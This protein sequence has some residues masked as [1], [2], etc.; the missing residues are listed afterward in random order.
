MLRKDAWVDWEKSVVEIFSMALLELLSTKSLPEKENDL[1]RLLAI[2]LRECRR[3]WC[4]TN[5]RELPGHPFSRLKDN[6]PQG[7]RLKSRKKTKSRTL[8][9]DLPII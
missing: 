1:N 2:I 9:G 3:K 6:Q 8:P 5:D 7:M 4:L